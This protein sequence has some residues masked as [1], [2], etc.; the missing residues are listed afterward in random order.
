MTMPAPVAVPAEAAVVVII[1]VLIAAMVVTMAAVMFV[2][3][4]LAVMLT[5]LLM[6]VA[7]TAIC[8]FS[9]VLCALIAT[10]SPIPASCNAYFCCHGSVLRGKRY[11]EDH[12]CE[13]AVGLRYHLSTSR[14]RGSPRFMYQ[15]MWI[16]GG[17]APP[18][19]VESMAD[20]YST[21]YG[22]WGRQGLHPGEPVKLTPERIRK[23]MYVLLSA[24]WIDCAQLSTVELACRGGTLIQQRRRAY[25]KDALRWP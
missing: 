7:M 11:G 18:D 8:H 14:V 12:P 25:A 5:I 21:Q 23:S 24:P 2:I 1:V 17:L 13:V 10:S 4:M 3:I 9:H 16:P 20:L 22:T 19:L 6:R 15:Y